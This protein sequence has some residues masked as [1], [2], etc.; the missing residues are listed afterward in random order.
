MESRTIRQPRPCRLFEHIPNP[1]ANKRTSWCA[2]QFPIWRHF[3]QEE[4]KT[5]KEFTL[6]SLLTQGLE[7]HDSLR[8]ICLKEHFADESSQDSLVF[9]VITAWF[10]SQEMP[11]SPGLCFFSWIP[12]PCGYI[13]GCMWQFVL[14]DWDSLSGLAGRCLDSLV[15]AG[16]AGRCWDTWLGAVA[17]DLFIYKRLFVCLSVHTYIR[18]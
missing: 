12:C 4:R 8:S 15:V 7:S 10:L 16:L 3:S 18:T 13:H 5:I 11:N 2:P 9:P 6:Q 1:P 17:S 14:S